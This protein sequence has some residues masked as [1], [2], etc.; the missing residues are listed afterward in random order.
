MT[1]CEADLKGEIFFKAVYRIRLEAWVMVAI[2]VL[3]LIY[4]QIKLVT[5]VHISTTLLGI[6]QLGV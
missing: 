2:I 6:L 5:S 4:E 3:V 1:E